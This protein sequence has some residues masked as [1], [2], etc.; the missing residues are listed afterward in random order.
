MRSLH[1][2]V[3]QASDHDLDISAPQDVDNIDG[4]DL[5]EALCQRY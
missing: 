1:Q 3:L 4:L 5:L 2:S